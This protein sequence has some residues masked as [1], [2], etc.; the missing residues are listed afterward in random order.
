[1]KVFSQVL[2]DELNEILNLMAEIS[3]QENKY[4]ALL[5]ADQPL[6]TLKD[7]RLEIK[8]LKDKLSMLERDALTLFN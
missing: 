5:E 8:R 3:L 1:M 6:K 4:A 2:T 7:I